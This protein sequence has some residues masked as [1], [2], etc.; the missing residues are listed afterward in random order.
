MQNNDPS[1]VAA[2]NAWR[3][4]GSR[5]DW[6]RHT[7]ILSHGPDAIA[8]SMFKVFGF[9]QLIV[10]NTSVYRGYTD[11]VAKLGVPTTVVDE[12][13]V[14]DKLLQEWLSMNSTGRAREYLGADWS[15]D[16]QGQNADSRAG[17]TALAS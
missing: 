12:A 14:C 7:L 1:S 16:T 17:T 6:A 3:A 8:Y 2:M 11:Q 9:G 5:N 4:A 15:K 10:A 13:R